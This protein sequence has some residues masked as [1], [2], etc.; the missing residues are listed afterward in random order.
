MAMSKTLERQ[1][2]PPRMLPSKTILPAHKPLASS[3]LRTGP[4]WDDWVPEARVRKP[5]ADNKELQQSLQKEYAA[6][7]KPPVKPTSSRKKAMGSDMSSGRGSE[8]RSSVPAGRGTKRG[9][10][11][12]IEKVSYRSD[13]HTPKQAVGPQPPLIGSNHPEV[14][15]QTVKSKGFAHTVHHCA[16]R[17]CVQHNWMLEEEEED[18]EYFEP[19]LKLIPYYV[20]DLSALKIL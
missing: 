17:Y 8:D 19:L 14:R 9:R 18:E 4:R 3:V 11:M 5:T 20:D 10:D 13:V 12:E 6:A 1:S 16:E 7:R 2:K 15:R